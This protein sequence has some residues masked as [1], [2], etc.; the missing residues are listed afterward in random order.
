M[1]QET[2]AS[3]GLMKCAFSGSLIYSL[4]KKKA[5]TGRLPLPSRSPITGIGEGGVPKNR[6]CVKK[7]YQ[8]NAKAKVKYYTISAVKSSTTN[9]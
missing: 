8:N 1:A 9:I 2:K 7:E 6:H 4:E 3:H 5:K